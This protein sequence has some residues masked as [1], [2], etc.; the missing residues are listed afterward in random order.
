MPRGPQTVCLWS[1]VALLFLMTT[2][3]TSRAKEFSL[4][5]VG[6]RAGFSG[7]GSGEDFN[8][9]EFFA[10]WNLPWLW[11][12]GRRWYLEPRADVSLGWLGDRTDNAAIGTLGPSLVL[13]HGTIPVTLE[14]GIGP[15]LLSQHDFGTKD[16]GIKLQFTSHVGVDWDVTSRWR[17]GYRFQH[18]SNGGLSDH[19]PGL[20]MHMLGISY[21]F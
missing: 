6:F 4:E 16:F 19:N 9:A 8:Q 10:N 5:T 7:P 1:A 12:L 2:A 21:L 3:G 20:N 14:G 15:T 17:L 18:M 11:N 13:S